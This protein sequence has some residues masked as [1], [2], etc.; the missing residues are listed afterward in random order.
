MVDL[1]LGLNLWIRALKLTDWDEM[2]QITLFYLSYGMLSKN[3]EI[4]NEKWD[5]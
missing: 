2:Y 4:I 1:T 5:Y 3:M